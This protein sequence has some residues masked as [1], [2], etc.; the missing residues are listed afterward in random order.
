MDDKK[1]KMISKSDE[2]PKKCPKCMKKTLIKQPIEEGKYTLLC[3]SCGL[4]RGAFKPD[5][6][7]GIV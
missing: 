6:K 4:R 1:P 2:F 3:I 5:K 7:K